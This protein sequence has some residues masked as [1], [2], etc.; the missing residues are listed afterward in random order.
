MPLEEVSRP[1][2]VGSY[3][4]VEVGLTLLALINAPAVM[5]L[6]LLMVDSARFECPR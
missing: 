1:Q 6:A 5:C 3:Q 2:G 4:K